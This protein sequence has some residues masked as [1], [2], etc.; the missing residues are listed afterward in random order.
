MPSSVVTGV[1]QTIS[2]IDGWTKKLT[3]EQIS[4][5]LATV[6]GFG[7][8]FYDGGLEPNYSIL[9]KET[10]AHSIGLAGKA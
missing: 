2:G 3:D 1:R 8:N 7:I 6:N 5:I 9:H 10:L 4:Q